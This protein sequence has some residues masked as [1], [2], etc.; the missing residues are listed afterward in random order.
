MTHEEITIWLQED[1]PARLGELYR[2]ADAARARHVGDEVHLRGL[3]EISNHCRRRCGYCGLNAG[4][5]D[6]PRYRM[7][8]GEILDG[9][10]AAVQY[11]YG[12]VVLQSGEDPGLTGEG[13]AEVIRAIKA[14]T[15]LAVT[16]SLGERDERELQRWRDAGADRYLLRFETSNPALYEA[17]HP[18]LPGVR[19]DRFAL[20][21]RLRELGY[22]IGSGVMIG[23]P[24]QTFDDLARDIE[25][26]AALDLDM[27][28]VGPYIAHPATDLG[29]D[30]APAARD[31]VPAD[32]DTTYK[33]VALAR[34]VCPRANIPSTS[35]LATLNLATGRELGLQRGAN[36]VMPNLT[37]VRYR[38][39][40]EIYPSKACI[41]ETAEQCHGCMRRRIESIGR[42]PGRGRGDSPN[43]RRAEAMS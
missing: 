17:I 42:R 12:T 6:V 24:G 13:M 34:L 2:R 14:E 15:P 18:S 22:E 31:Q 25:T 32:E 9:A 33:V 5:P 20:L 28:G 16:L 27:I 38:A 23:I 19:S 39:S 43:Y 37:P 8:A 3:L 10:R 11:G 1:D 7:S 30:A 26:F 29:R 36:V 41:R 35:A 21:R 40:Y 4:N